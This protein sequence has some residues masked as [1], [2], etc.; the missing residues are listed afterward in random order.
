[1][2]VGVY[3]F[4]GNE[5]KLCYCYE[6]CGNFQAEATANNAAVNI[7]VCVFWG[8]HMS[9]SIWSTRLRVELLEQTVNFHYSQ[10]LSYKVTANTELSNTETLLLGEIQG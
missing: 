9:I 3:S 1:M 10:N 2:N 5:Q 6:L 7:L 8:K 4:S